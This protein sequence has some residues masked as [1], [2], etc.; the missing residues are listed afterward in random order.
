MATEFAKAPN[1]CE[2]NR[3]AGYGFAVQIKPVG[4]GPEEYRFVRGLTGVSM[5]VEAATASTSDIDS[6]E[7]DSEEKTT[8]KLT[9]TLNGQ[10]AQ[11]G[12]L[13]VLDETQELLK[14]T[15]EEVGANGKIDLRIWSTVVDEGWEGTFNNAFQAAEASRENFREFTATL[16]NSCAPT[17]I[18]SVEVGGEKAESKPLDAAE[19]KKLISPKG[20]GSAGTEAGPGA[21]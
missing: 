2:L 15:G 18:H 16:T 9:V 13:P 8:R 5:A 21:A 1:S 11:K 10:F 19:I 4:A 17:R 7:W 12:T 3:L 14:F 20:A 6:G